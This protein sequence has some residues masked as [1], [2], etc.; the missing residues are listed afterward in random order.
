MLFIEP[1]TRLLNAVKKAKQLKLQAE[2]YQEGSQ[3]LTFNLSDLDA[4]KL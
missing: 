4:S 1:E 3:V 2:Y